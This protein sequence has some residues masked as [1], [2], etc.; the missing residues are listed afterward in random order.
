VLRQQRGFLG[1]LGEG[2]IDDIDRQQVGLARIEAALED[3]DVGDAGGCD[4]QRLSGS[5]AQRSLGV[6][7]GIG[8][9]AQRQPDFR[10]TDHG[11]AGPW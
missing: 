9:R 1:R 11:L 8:G 7:F 2:D 4:A 10:E 5:G 6:G 3:V